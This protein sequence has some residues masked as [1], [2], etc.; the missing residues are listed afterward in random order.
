M[1]PKKKPCGPK[2]LDF[3]CAF[4]GVSP[5]FLKELIASGSIRVEQIGAEYR[6]PSSELIRLALP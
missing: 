2:D 3:A 1:E 5:R 6:I 4:L